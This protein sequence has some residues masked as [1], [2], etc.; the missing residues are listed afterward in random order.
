MLFLAELPEG[1]NKRCAL[2]LVTSRICFVFA[3]EKMIFSDSTLDSLLALRNIRL[4][5][6]EA[7][8]TYADKCESCAIVSN[9]HQAYHD[10]H[11]TTGL[12]GSSALNWMPALHRDA[13]LSEPFVPPQAPVY[14][15]SVE[16]F[17][18]PLKYIASIRPEAEP[19]G[20]CKVV[21]PAGW[22]PSFELD[23]STFRFKTRVQS[24]HELQNRRNASEAAE[25]FQQEYNAFLELTS[26]P[27]RKAPVLG[28]A[29]LDLAKLYS[30]VQK[31][32]G[33]HAVTQKKGWRE[34]GR[35]LQVGS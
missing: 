33:Y 29:T 23:K 4:P 20:I 11:P 25:A 26:R 5:R 2:T 13:L 1:V 16:E 18:H 14:R 15:P 24:V 6:Y 9:A 19:Y 35:V 8:L 22:Q 21:P 12:P 10:L 28:G 32:G 34:I 7:C 3:V 31:K 17:E 30:T 27:V